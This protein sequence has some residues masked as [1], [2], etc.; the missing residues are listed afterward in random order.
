VDLGAPGVDVLSTWYSSD[1]EF[2][3]ESGT[4]MSAPHVSGVAALILSKFPGADI[5][6]LR[7][8]LLGGVDPLS[9]LDGRTV[10]GGRLN[11]YHALT[12]AGNGV[13]QVRIMPPSGSA[14]LAG[15]TQ[16]IRV[17]VTEPPLSVS[18]ATV[19][20]SVAGV[21]NLTFRNDGVAPDAV[22]NDRI[23][24]AALNVPSATNDL[25]LSVDASSPGK[26][27][28]SATA[29]YS[30][31]P[32]PVNDFFTNAVKV[33]VAG[34]TYRENNLFATR[35]TGEPRHA[36]AQESTASLWWNYTPAQTVA[37]YLDTLGSAGDTVLGV[38]LGNSVGNLSVVASNN[39]VGPVRQAALSFT[40]V[41]GNTY[42]IALASANSNQVGSVQLRVAPGGG[43]D[44]T[45]PQVFMT[46]PLN[47]QIV[48]TNLVNVTG[49]A[50]DP[51]LNSSGVS[52]VQV[53]IN[54]GF[55]MTAS[56]TTNW[57]LV[58]ALDEGLNSISAQAVDAA[59][60]VSSPVMVQV[61]YFIPGP[62][63]D[64][65]VNATA[66]G[67]SPGSTVANN[68]TATAEAG[69][70]W[71]AGVNGNKSLWWKF[72]PAEDGTLYLSTLGS[73]FD[74]LLA[75]YTGD[76]V[77]TLTPVIANDDAFPNAPGGYSAL[78]LGARAGQT[79]HI[80]VD[81]YDGLSGNLVLSNRF[82]PSPV[83]QLIVE[84]GPGGT[85]TPAFLDVGAGTTV[86][87]TAQPAANYLF[88]MWSGD[89]VSLA[90]PLNLVVTSNTT[91]YA[92]F[93]P[94]EFTEG[95]ESGDFSQLPWASGGNLPWLVRTNPVAAGQ[96]AARSGVINHNQSSSLIFSGDFED[97]QVT[98]AYK[99]S[100]ELGFDVLKFLVDGVVR[101]Q[102]S[103]EVGWADFTYPVTAGFHT[104]E[105]RYVKDSTLSAGADAAYLDNL[106]L[107]LA[108]YDSPVFR[109]DL[110][111]KRLAD[112][113]TLVDLTGQPGQTY[114][115]QASTDMINWQS[116]ATNVAVGGFARAVDTGSSAKPRNYFRAIIPAQP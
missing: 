73:S 102:W 84:S 24:T 13:L 10:T 83:Y 56:G 108:V 92:E 27:G 7:S 76:A 107:P 66:L 62:P 9:S 116:F 65:F 8:R 59:G 2:F 94:M 43:P 80:A 85:A 22:A 57:D 1:T 36:G 74:T 86:T 81:G 45:P 35:E 32:P 15:S 30:V 82:T 111:I 104:L 90:N 99:V 101:E 28:A 44:V 58:V 61:N 78:T 48:T 114:V 19:T 105:W 49:T 11:A 112:G 100:S 20:G 18:N 68:S 42:R 60:N 69:E 52:E 95:F 64:F 110:E 87:I 39:N 103:G 34:A 63:N 33:P 77:S 51:V 16:S 17:E 31:L 53:S 41:A 29:T 50:M 12:L 79:Y 14:L 113:T 26:T 88:D 6:E 71:H 97:G 89:V 47:G 93:R 40:A 67:A 98:F 5:G 37:V 70:P 72:T 23:Y 38:Y 91:L 54:G 106:N 75:I 109:P 4:S 25:T 96:F 21:G 55:A 115:F 3:T 46:S